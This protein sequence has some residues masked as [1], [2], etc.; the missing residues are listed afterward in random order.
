MKCRFDAQHMDSVD[1][2]IVANL[3]IQTVQKVKLFL[4]IQVEGCT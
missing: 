2:T 1:A 3:N 4:Q